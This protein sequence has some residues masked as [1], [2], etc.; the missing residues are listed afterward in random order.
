MICDW[1]EPIEKQKNNNKKAKPSK[2][3]RERD[4]RKPEL[5]ETKKD[6]LKIYIESLIY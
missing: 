1:Q 6:M 3:G 2:C 4:D 5:H